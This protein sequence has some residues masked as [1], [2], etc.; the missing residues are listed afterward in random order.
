M[1]KRLTVLLVLILTICAIFATMPTVASA[2]QQ[3]NQT[4]TLLQDFI[5][6]YPDRSYDLDDFT[7]VAIY[8][9]EQFVKM[10]VASD[11]VVL[12]EITGLP[13]QYNVVA[14][15]DNPNTTKTVVVGAHY[16]TAYGEGASDNAC[17]VV[18][19][20]QIAQ[21]LTQDA[22]QL[23]FDVQLVAFGCEE[24]GMDGSYYFVNSL[25]AKQKQDLLLMINID[26]I[27]TGDNL[28]VFC[29]N[30][31][32][33]LQDA[34]IAGSQNSPV[35][36]HSKPF[37]AGLF[38][39]FDFYYFGYWEMAQNS[40]HTPFRLEGIP[41]AFFF[42][43]NY[44]GKYYG[45]FES[46]DKS[47][48]VTNTPKDTLQNLI[49]NHP[50]FYQRVQTVVDT[51]C[52]TLQNPQNATVIEDARNHLLPI[53]NKYWYYDYA[54][55]I[56]FVI[57]A[58]VVVFGISYYKKLKKKAILGVAEVVNKQVFTSPDADDIFKY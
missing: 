11:N 33:P 42:S 26:T 21:K 43:G 17:G 10:G 25:T 22:T 56:A 1:N 55:L 37:N 51:V 32:T 6:N 13:G 20:W 12:Q 18:A 15:I 50:D 57:V 44:N 16:D 2:N 38:S 58:V 14:T 48:W 28:Y 40:D 9:G 52:N 4:L 30:K 27:A 54:P 47:K 36:L 3:D 8:V 35:K 23:P 5:A 7:Q 19:L 53:G 31:A 29:E 45:Y 49:T 34:F 46:A 41:T 39:T 24:D